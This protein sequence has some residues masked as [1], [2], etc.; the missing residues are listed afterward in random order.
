MARSTSLLLSSSSVHL[1]DCL[2]GGY[3]LAAVHLTTTAH[4]AD[5]HLPRERSEP[6]CIEV[7]EIH[8]DLFGDVTPN[9][10]NRHA[11]APDAPRL[12]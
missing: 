1:P 10:R 12:G 2:L 7:L 4:D 3:T 11:N 8:R 5:S 6:V 9:V